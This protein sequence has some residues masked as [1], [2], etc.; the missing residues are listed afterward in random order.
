MAIRMT[1]G[2]DLAALG[3]WCQDAGGEGELLVFARGWIMRASGQPDFIIEPDAAPLAGTHEPFTPDEM[4]AAIVL[5]ETAK[6]NHPTGWR[7]LEEIGLKPADSYVRYAFAN[8]DL[9]LQRLVG[10]DRR[11]IYAAGWLNGLGIGAGLSA[12]RR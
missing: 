2:V 5:L 10:E 3:Q 11:L 4:N 6:Q 8:A 7:C 1:G 9:H 12:G